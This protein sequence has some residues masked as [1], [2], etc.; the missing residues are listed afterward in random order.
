MADQAARSALPTPLAAGAAFPCPRQP[1]SK[2]RELCP[3][4]QE[5]AAARFP[6]A[7]RDAAQLL[8]HRSVNLRD[9]RLVS[10][11]RQQPPGDIEAAPRSRR[12]SDR[13]DARIPAN[14]SR[15]IALK[16]LGFRYGTR[17]IY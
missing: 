5:R 17:S 6:T 7:R 1:P 2:E 9:P 14:R 13:S 12:R 15:A 4:A 16:K 3:N 10:R 11:A 8:C